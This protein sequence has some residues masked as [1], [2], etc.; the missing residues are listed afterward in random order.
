MN[1]T[2]RV[3][4]MRWKETEGVDGLG[5]E[6]YGTGMGSGAWADSRLGPYHLVRCSG[7]SFDL[8]TRIRV[9][10]ERNKEVWVWSNLKPLQP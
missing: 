1:E 9:I 8:L 3:T 4:A 7:F 6:V 5:S 10:I 2:D